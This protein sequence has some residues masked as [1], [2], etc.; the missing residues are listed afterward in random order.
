MERVTEASALNDL[1]LARS[2][3]TELRETSPEFD[4]LVGQR[5]VEYLLLDDYGMGAVHLAVLTPHGF[6]WL[7]APDRV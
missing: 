1:E 3:V 7:H 5:L 2:T 4:G 6:A